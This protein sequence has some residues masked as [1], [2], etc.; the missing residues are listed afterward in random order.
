MAQN[1]DLSEI[2]KRLETY[3]LKIPEVTKH[4]IDKLSQKQKVELNE[5]ILLV[6]TETIHMANFDPKI[7]LTSE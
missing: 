3:S 7:Y 2:D 5:R 4:Y 6:I 1:F